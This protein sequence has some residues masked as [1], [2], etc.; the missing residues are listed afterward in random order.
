MLACGLVT[1]V[2][3]SAAGDVELPEAEEVHAAA[4]GALG[5]AHLGATLA[6]LAVDPTTAL[7]LEGVALTT[8]LALKAAPAVLVAPGDIALSP[9]SKDR[10]TRD[11]DLPQSAVRYSN[12][13]GFTW[14]GVPEDWGDLGAPF[15]LHSNSE[16]DVSV[17]HPYLHLNTPQ[18]ASFPAGRHRIEWTAATQIDPFFDVAL[19]TATLALNYSKLEA[20]K[21]AAAAEAD[22]FAM[23]KSLGTFKQYANWL[24]RKL[25]VIPAKCVDKCTTIA[26]DFVTEFERDSVSTTRSQQ[27]TVFDELPPI[28]RLNQTTLSLEATDVGGVLT[29][30]VLSELLQSVDASDACDR[31][32][33]IEHDAPA[34]LPLGTTQVRWTVKDLGPVDSNGGF[35]SDSI[36]QTIVIEDTQ[37]PIMVPPPGRVIEVDPNGPEADGLSAADIEL[38]SPRVVDLADPMPVVASNA[39][40]FFP[41]DARTSVVWSATDQ[42]QN[43]ATA[44]Q[45]ITV[46]TL[47][48][49]TAPSV[50]DLSA[51]TLT[52]QPVDIV[53]SGLDNDLLGGFVDPLAFSI[54]ER[55]KNGGFVAPLLPFFIEDYRTAI[56]GPYPEEFVTSGNRGNW[57]FDNVCSVE[58]GPNNERIARDWVYSPRFVEVDDDG[59]YFILDAYWK[60]SSS[61]AS[62]SP[63]ISKWD[64]DGRYLGQVEYSGTNDAF[65]LDTEGF[66]TTIA[67]TGSG[68]SSTRF[69]LV[70]FLPNFENGTTQQVDRWEV[71]FTSSEDPDRGIRDFMNVAQF[72]SAHLDSEA[73]LL[74]VNDSANVF[75]FDVSAELDSPTDD[76]INPLQMRSRYLGALTGDN[77]AQVSGGNRFLCTSGV[78]GSNYSGFSMRNDSNGNLF[79]TDSC[80]DRIHKF[81]P[82]SV[83]GSGV[84]NRGS[85]T[86]WLGR[87][88]SSTN[89]ACDVEN[90]HSR[91]YNCKNN[92][93]SGTTN[94]SDPGQLD[95]PVYLAID[96]NDILYVADRGRVQRFTPDGTFAGEARSVGTGINQGERPGFVL[97]N[98]G[99]VKTVSVNSNNFFVV[100]QAE[101]FIH[102]FETTPLKDITASSATVS[103]VSNFN[104]HSGTDSFR[105]AASDG[106][107][108]SNDGTVSIRVDR[109]FRPPEAFS[110]KLELAEDTTLAITLTGDDPDGVIGTDDV[111]PL[112]SLTYRIVDGPSNGAIT[113]D[114]SGANRVYTPN[115]D[116]FGID[117]FT[118][119]AHDG[120]FESEPATIELVVAA[121]DDAPRIAEFELPARVGIGF[122]A[123]L[124][125][126]YTDDGASEAQQVVV[127]WGGVTETNGELVDPDGE[128]DAGPELQGLHVTEPPER[129]GRGTVYGQHTYTAANSFQE[130]VICLTGS[131][132]T[133]CD[134]KAT[135]IEHLVALNVDMQ[136]SEETTSAPFIDV[137]LSVVNLVPEGVAGLSAA[138]VVLRQDDSELVVTNI[139]NDSG[140]C[141]IGVEGIGCSAANLEPGDSFSATLRIAPASNGV[142]LFDV[143]EPFAVDVTTTSNSVEETY[144]ELLWL[145]FSADTTDSDGDGI[146]DVYEQ[147]YGLNPNSSADASLDSD[148]DGL[149]NLEEYLAETNPNQADTDGDQIPDSGD[150]CPIDSGGSIDSDADGLCDSFH[151]A[152]IDS[153]GDGLTDLKEVEIFLD[154]MNALDAMSDPDGDGVSSLA[155]T[156]AGTDPYDAQS[157]PAEPNSPV[158]VSSVLPSSR[159]VMRGTQA[160][161]FATLINA[162]DVDGVGCSLSPMTPMNGTF[163]FQITDSAT[164]GAVG[165]PNELVDI[166]AGA[167]QSFVFGV[168]PQAQ[169]APTEMVIRYACENLSPANF[170]VGI[171]TLLLAASVL[172]TPDIV[173]LTATASGDGVVRMT[174]ANPNG[175][176]A[177][178][179][180]NVGSSGSLVARAETTKAGIPVQLSLCQTD[181]QGLCVNPSVPVPEVIL[182]VEANETPTFSIF[183][184]ASGAIPFAPAEN[185]VRV[186]FTDGNGVV[187]GSSS[188]ALTRD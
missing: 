185:R 159:S 113:G 178:A 10:C 179:T 103:Y 116:F 82:S 61:S 119:V 127:D 28:I 79:V 4:L 177:L 14:R 88:E 144:T 99:E 39:P 56:Q 152:L 27:L 173:A 1:L 100:D 132:G 163:F 112:D 68:G 148:R 111:L 70:R 73:G 72:S 129:I 146:S 115:A 8:N 182:D 3:A 156:R 130:V 78:Y 120:R 166:P 158:L 46:K 171:N 114:A 33:S 55:P 105:Y 135:S 49:N 20:N 184:R 52:S 29:A 134:S 51:A 101:S 139:M 18:R 125:A 108:S 11:F 145:T 154:P 31:P 45:L 58:T 7:T 44:T 176:F 15:V 181:T 187:R 174:S 17:R 83:E 169:A 117:R 121:V 16:V 188:V 126:A 143:S 155:E 109:N 94:G 96:S 43:L 37:A 38:G 36:V 35:N 57:L 164:N 53:L 76:S 86:G 161:A 59:N 104:F 2:V 84:F 21:L 40:S 97:G 34:L 89:N 98:L 26:A 90:Q 67:R 123:V 168:T 48:T 172:P 19:P 180:V 141:T 22:L 75:V 183:T 9:N 102:V 32:V 93:C 137:E 142:P 162:G 41:L 12:I 81:G 133:Q 147:F 157:V 95:E 42:S 65:V 23:Q 80:T 153:D 165:M 136:A 64:A 140:N 47:G 150:Q 74:Y 110:D 60:C 5:G 175:A 186:V 85:Y 63:R 149:T 71:S 54:T 118:Y 167:V 151:S 69:A 77:P 124:Q 128:G 160:T 92:T 138:N 62:T 91:G 106:L 170:Q 6:A 87:C 50:T 131:S 24:G 25:S 66:I 13:F 107:A 30:R 122:P